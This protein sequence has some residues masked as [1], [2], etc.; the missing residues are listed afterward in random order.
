MGSV[1]NK[2]NIEKDFHQ[3]RF[4][5]MPPKRVQ[6]V[7]PM[8]GITHDENMTKLFALILICQPPSK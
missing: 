4:T 8:G 7:R 1:L 6:R 3:S 5:V 2:G